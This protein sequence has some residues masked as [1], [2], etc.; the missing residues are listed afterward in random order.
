MAHRLKLTDLFRL[1]A[2]F[3]LQFFTKKS[4]FG[5][6]L[7]INLLCTVFSLSSLSTQANPQF[8]HKQS[9]SVSAM[10]EI[11]FN[12]F[13]TTKSTLFP[14]IY[15]VAQ[16]TNGFIWVGTQ[17]GLYRYDGHDFKRYGLDVEDKAGFKSHFINQ[18]HAD[19]HGRVWVATKEGVNLLYPELNTFKEFNKTIYPKAFLGNNYIGVVE[20]HEGNL[21]FAS[22]RHGLTFFDIE[23]NTFTTYLTDENNSKSISSNIINDILITKDNSLVIATNKGVDVKLA[24]SENFVRYNSESA[25]KLPF[26]RVSRI[27]ETQ[28]G[29]IWL[30]G[31]EDG[32]ARISLSEGIEKH[33]VYQENNPSSLCSNTI[34]NILEDSEKQLWIATDKGLCQYSSSSDSFK[35]HKHQNDRLTSLPHDWVYAL[36]QDAGGVLWVG[37]S[38]GLTNWNAK[39]NRFLHISKT[40]GTNLS[41]DV[42]TSFSE[43]NNQNLY[44]GTWGGGVNLFSA[45]LQQTIDNDRLALI[46]DQLADKHIGTVLFDS[47]KNLWIGTVRTG[48]YFVANDSTHVENLTFLN[49]QGESTSNNSITKIVEL[50][51]GTIVIAILGKGIYFSLGNGLFSPITLPQEQQL[52]TVFDIEEDDKGLIWFSTDGEGVYVYDRK[53]KIIENLRQQEDAPNALK[54]NII[55]SVLNTDKYI[56]LATQ[57]GG[58]VRVNKDKYYQGQM[59]FSIVRN[60]KKIIINSAYGLLEDERGFIWASHGLGISRIHPEELSLTHFNTTHNLQGLDFNVGADYKASNGRMYFGG[61]NGF[62]SISG[63]KIPVNDNPPKLKLLEFSIFNEPVE[64]KSVINSHG[65]LVL[66]HS[67]SV[68]GFEFAALDYTEP[69]KNQ[70]KYQMLGLSERWVD[71]KDNR[72]TFSN[73]T[74]GNYTLRIQGSNNDGIWSQDTLDVDL[75]VKPPFWKTVTAY[76]IYCMFLIIVAGFLFSRQVRKAH[77]QLRYQQKLKNLVEERTI[78]LRQVNANLE[79][80]MVETEKAKDIAESAAKAKAEF[81]ATMSHEIRTPMNSILGMNELLLKTNLSS[82]QKKYASM[83]FRSGEALLALINDIL[84][85]SKMEDNKITLEK[86]RFDLPKLVEDCV[87]LLRPIKTDNLVKVVAD[88]DPNCPQFIDGDELRYRQVLTNLISNAIKFTKQGSVTVKV[89]YIKEEL[90]ISVI[91]TGIGISLENQQNIFAAFEQ[92]DSSTTRRF[93]GTGL[94]LSITKKIVDLMQG[95]IKVESQLHK[96]S[97]FEVRIPIELTDKEG[98]YLSAK[99]DVSGLDFKQVADAKIALVAMDRKLVKLAKS[100]LQ[101]LHL[102]FQHINNSEHIFNFIKGSNNEVLLMEAEMLSHLDWQIKLRDNHQRIICMYDQSDDIDPTEYEDITFIDKSIDIKELY[103]ELVGKLN[104]IQSPINASE[105]PNEQQQFNAKVLLVEDAYTNQVVATEMLTLFGCDVDVAENGLEAFN[106]V[107]ENDYDIIF[108]DCQMPIMDGFEATRKIRLW[109]EVQNQTPGLIIALTAGKGVGYLEECLGVGMD[110]FMLKPFNFNQLH[111]ILNKYLAHLSNGGA[112]LNSDEQDS[113]ESIN[114]DELLDKASLDSIFQIE[115]NSGRKIFHKVLEIFKQEMQNKLPEL[116]NAYVEQESKLLYQCAHAIKSS[117][118][119]VGAKKLAELCQ[120]IETAGLN[121]DFLICSN[122]IKVIQKTYEQS[123][124]QLSGL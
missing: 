85:F 102:N 103:T 13:N 69:D 24:N 111:D 81:L 94:G 17:S 57:D 59:D 32:L 6:A 19:L 96:G 48:M 50:N 37:T 108:M 93:G 91:D 15:D 89:I 83:A 118:G 44:V 10:Q 107:R 116:F 14:I 54:S 63:D 21:W 82:A 90:Q 120:V 124:E 5:Y 7:V 99:T 86:I 109:Q 31:D 61:V 33:F 27:F 114:A 1:I 46:N 47:N 51:D 28:A 113:G 65:Q 105:A 38:G 112:A 36:F 68:I 119:N 106:C 95:N 122:E 104:E 75:L 3:V 42:I 9:T 77:K 60:D 35:Q 16:D 100:S 26:N 29:K 80:S 67:D 115:I 62:N 39:L 23:A 97:T 84:D 73:L 110:D 64:L 66:K 30:G 55:Y 34:M 58:I 41:S 98:S 74:D 53:N 123:I 87:Y 78:E 8:E 25:F 71:L 22:D 121:D 117:A 18:V 2:I 40:L 49:A 76:I 88:I 92:A 12:N 45:D 4:Y 20:D 11:H 56:W 52:L 72:I 43:D 70:Y 79:K 101:K